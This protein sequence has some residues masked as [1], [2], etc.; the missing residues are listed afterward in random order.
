MATTGQD[1]QKTLGSKQNESTSPAPTLQ[2]QA[3]KPAAAS[4]YDLPDQ[5]FDGEM[6]YGVAITIMADG[7]QSTIMIPDASKISKGE[8]VY[9][10][11]RVGIHGK[12]LM[13]F[14]KAKGVTLPAELSGFIGNTTIS[15]DAFYYSTRPVT[16][17]KDDDK[18]I[19]VKQRLGLEDADWANWLKNHAIS[20]G[21]EEYKIDEGP[22]L[23]M[24][25]I[26]FDKGLIGSL[27]KDEH[28][29]DLF[30]IS[31]GSIRIVRCPIEK[32]DTLKNYVKQ[33]Q[34]TS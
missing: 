29:G 23:M 30:D 1:I 10:T 20:E 2:T 12:A 28:L 5:V 33:L 19:K 15:C 11:G 8:P 9:T 17:K 27:T 22:L 31:G 34:Q 21:S 18:Y 7:K 4:A 6:H 14:L 25:A 13:D 26:N 32:V 3:P 16:F 24:F